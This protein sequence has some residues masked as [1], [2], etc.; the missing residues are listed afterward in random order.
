ML[1]TYTPNVPVCKLSSQNGTTPLFAATC[2]GHS[3]VAELLLIKGAD[4]N[5]SEQVTYT[6]TPAIHTMHFLDIGN[7]STMLVPTL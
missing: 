5:L 4:V 7:F 3:Q 2:S 1:T 6:M